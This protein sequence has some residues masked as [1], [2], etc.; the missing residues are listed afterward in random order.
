MSLTGRKTKIVAT[1]GPASQS[2]EIIRALIEAG[3]NVV[4]LNFSHGTHEDHKKIYDIVR[5]E[6][7]NQ[8][9]H[10]AVLVD[11]CGPKVRIGPVEGG[12]LFLEDGSL[13]DLKFL[14]RPEN[15]GKEGTSGEL[16]IEAFDPVAVLRIGQK[17]LLADGRILLIASE[18]GPDFVRCRVISGGKLRSRSGISVPDSQL[19]LPCLTDKD[20]ADL[21]WA[22]ENKVDYIALSFVGS[23]KDVDDA[24]IEMEKFGAK[25]PV[26][27]KIERASS[28]DEISKI[29][30]ASDA[31]MVA[32]GDLGLELPLERVPAAQRFIISE[33]NLTGTPVITATQMLMSMVNEIR[34]TRAEVS[35]VYT[36][37]RD[38]TDAVMLSDETAIGKFPVQS[39]QVLSSILLE[40]EKEAE[41][42]RPSLLGQKR[43]ARDKVADAVCFAASNASSKLACSGIIACTES[44]STARLM[45]KYRPQ[46][47]I[48]GA[49]SVRETLAK[50]ALYWGVEPLLIDIS[51]NDASMEYEV[52]QALLAARDTY[53]LKP[54]SRVLI[55]VGLRTKR[56]G[57]T[58]VMEVRE[59]PRTV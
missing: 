15:M 58:N 9:K 36:A 45:A 44:G 28:L 16:Y 1:L 24:H 7:S 40:A 17:A 34:P 32:R 37:V 27:S 48:F 35:D 46:A 38:G 23:A 54:G 10:I 13:I 25:I 49:T 41:L 8:Q 4:R 39:V 14:L 5:E 42:N 57:S 52:S 30:E 55:T 29:V 59:V 20:K 43:A 21:L 18:L 3:I 47:P 31:V 56:T 12:E 53:G 26:I 22:I 33:A 11:L 50:M 2:P 51:S 6:A 19:N